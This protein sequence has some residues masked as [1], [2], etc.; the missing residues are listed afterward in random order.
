MR[1]YVLKQRDFDN[2][3]AH[4]NR[5]P[6]RGCDGGSSV[7]MSEED[8]KAHEIAFRFFNYQICTWISD[9]QRE[10]E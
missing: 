1:I 8:R 6:C 9:V 4:I 7:V 3:L 2:L 5:D 10:G